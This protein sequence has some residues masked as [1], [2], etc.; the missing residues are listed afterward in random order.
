MFLR[1]SLNHSVRG[2]KDLEGMKIPFIGEIPSTEGKRHWWQRKRKQE[3]KI[4]VV[5]GSKN[6]INES[7]R[8]LRTKLDYFL[9]KNQDLKVVM[10]TSFNPGSGKTFISANL[11]KTFAIRGKRVI[12]LDMDLRHHSLSSMVS[13][14]KTGMS[15]Y[16]NGLVDNYK[17]IIIKDGLSENVDIIPVGIV[18]PNPTELL[19]SPRMEE[20][21]SKLREEYDYI[22]MDCPPVEI[23]ADA[24]IVKDFVDVSLFVVR[25]GLMDRRVLPMV[26]DLYTEEKYKRLAIVLNGTSHISGKY[27]HYRYGYTYGYTNGYAYGYHDRKGN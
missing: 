24:S 13:K 16:L 4:V 18:P 10:I 1:E 12:C 21:I 22:F 25:A 20:L 8:L 5:E 17:D 3:R 27:G 15:S 6:I 2:R 9:G 19:M 11:A 26:E 7:F 14:T 23:V